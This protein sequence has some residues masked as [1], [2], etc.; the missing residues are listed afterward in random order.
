MAFV[1]VPGADVLSIVNCR[2]TAV[3]NAS[4]TD[5]AMASGAWPVHRAASRYMGDARR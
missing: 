5:W 2:S 4:S 3:T 1:S